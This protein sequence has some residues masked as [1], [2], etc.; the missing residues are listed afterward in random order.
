MAI[1]SQIQDGGPASAPEP[2]QL[3]R[4]VMETHSTCHLFCFL[5][6]FRCL[7]HHCCPQSPGPWGG[8][9]QLV[10]YLRSEVGSEEGPAS[11]KPCLHSNEYLL[12]ISFVISI[13]LSNG[14][15]ALYQALKCD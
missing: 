1:G 11:R 10:P 3:F 15:S 13:T 5:L 8:L 7:P 6:V 4:N 2:P 9:S 14:A 12:A